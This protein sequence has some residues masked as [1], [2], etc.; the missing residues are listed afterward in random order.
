MK[1]SLKKIQ[2]NILNTWIIHPSQTLSTRSD[3]VHT[4]WFY[5][6]GTVIWTVSINA[7]F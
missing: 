2:P 1:H 4:R 3:K 5:N 7:I 6:Q